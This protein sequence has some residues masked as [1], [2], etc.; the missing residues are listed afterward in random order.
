MQVHRKTQRLSR[1]IQWTF[2][3][4]NWLLV[5]EDLLFMLKLAIKPNNAF[6]FDVVLQSTLLKQLWV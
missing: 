3:S 1:W 5:L 4:R 2:S 6:H